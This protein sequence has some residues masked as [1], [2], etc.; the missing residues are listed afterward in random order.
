MALPDDPFTEVL[1]TLWVLLETSSELTT[2]VKTGNRIKWASDSF[3]KSRPSKLTTTKTDLPE[4][5]VLPNGGEYNYHASSSSVKLIQRYTIGI[6]SWDLRIHKYFFPLKWA[7]IKVL[8][9]ADAN[10]GLDYVREIEVEDN[11]DVKSIERHP[12]WQAAFDISVMMVF[13]RTEM[14]A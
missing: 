8:A 7:V 3:A 12:G 10:L 1:Q 4:L 9:N 6:M 11:E 2:L 14:K 13:D 5:A